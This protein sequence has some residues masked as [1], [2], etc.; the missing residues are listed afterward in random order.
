MGRDIH[1]PGG[2]PLVCHCDWQYHPRFNG[3]LLVSCKKQLIESAWVEIFYVKTLEDPLAKKKFL[4]SAI[5]HLVLSV[6][7]IF[8]TS[9][10]LQAPYT[11]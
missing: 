11:G 2:N 7:G 1:G 4:C 3:M 8:L 9:F 6:M 5:C 10:I